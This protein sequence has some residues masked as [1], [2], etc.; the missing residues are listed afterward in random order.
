[1]NETN[2]HLAGGC[3]SEKEELVNRWTYAPALLLAIALPALAAAPVRMEAR[4]Y[5]TSYDEL[6]TKLGDLLGELD[7]C[8]HVEVEN[9]RSYLVIDTDQDQLKAIRAHGLSTEVT[10]PD[11]RDKFREVTGCNPD[12]GSFRDFGYFFNYWEMRDTLNRL[13]ANYPNI[14]V[15]ASPGNSYQGRPL[16][17]IKISDNPLVNEGE[18]QV[19]LNGAS[20][21]R[22]PLG[23]HACVT[24][25][26]LLCRNYGADSLVTWLVNNREIYIIPV[27]NPD[28]YVYNSDSGGSSANWRKNRNNQS[29][30][31]G[32][33]VDLNRNYGYKWGYD[34]SGSSGTPSSETYRGPSRFS[35]PETQVVRDFLAAHKVRT[36]NDFHTYGQYNMYPWGYASTQ[37]PERSL[38]QEC[39][40]TFRVNNQY[41]ANQTG[42]VYS[43]I[44]P[45]NGLSVDWEYADTL[46]NG[47]RKFITY[48]FTC[49]LGIN[50]FWYGSSNQTY[51]DQEVAKNTPN[52]YYLTRLCGVYLEPQG[53]VVND[54]TTGNGSGQLDP[55]E[56]ARLWFKVRNR[57]IHP[58]DTA[59]TVTAVLR[60]SD[61]MVHVNTPT[62]D[63]PSIPRRT[64]A[65]NSLSQIEV[66]CNPNATPGS[67][68][69]LRLEVTYTD[70]G[71]TIMQPVNYRITI[72]NQSAIGA[73]TPD[74]S[75][76]ALSLSAWPNPACSRTVFHATTPAAR[77]A[78][79]SIYAQD[80]RFVRTLIVPAGTTS[81]LMWD[82]RGATGRLVPAG[83][84]FARLASGL[85]GVWTKV[86][87]T[88]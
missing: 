60:T 39:V 28:G 15:M 12:D 83:V 63:F 11:I 71:V 59:K 62:A 72:G 84:Y 58:L 18:P 35:E 47:N 3:R 25:A 73:P 66:A 24:F 9:G 41:P 50:D 17:C 68:V 27:M 29:P 65:N 30:R 43:T 2:S 77:P 82:R 86:T 23:T 56:T 22:E 8:T 81:A 16:Y 6:A 32:P 61:T 21:A 52:C 1:M 88:D 57:A 45:C 31:T 75:N 70:D 4:V 55:G 38:L 79:L 5:Y 53:V 40:D 34:G 54:T 46:L 13:I 76:A 10:Y 87:L 33:G 20:H 69:T 64:D 80:G 44:Y 37:P 42:Q 7:I 51:V 19:F 36:C 14:A 26:S 78:S 48:A 85:E 49:E 74:Y 67:N